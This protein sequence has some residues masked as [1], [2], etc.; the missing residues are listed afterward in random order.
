MKQQ[1]IPCAAEQNVGDAINVKKT[2]EYSVMY[3]KL[4]EILA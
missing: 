2:A 1:N 3:P 4:T